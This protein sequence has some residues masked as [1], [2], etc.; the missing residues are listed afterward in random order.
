M[1]HLLPAIASA[2]LTGIGLASFVAEGSIGLFGAT[3]GWVAAIGLSMGVSLIVQRQVVLRWIRFGERPALFTLLPAIVATGLSIVG[4]APGAILIVQLSAM[5][6]GKLESQ[7][8]ETIVP[9]DDWML[10]FTR[11]QVELSDLEA[12]SIQKEERERTFGD[13]CGVQHKKACNQ[14]CRMRARHAATL[15]KSSAIGDDLLESAFTSR[16]MMSRAATVSEQQAAYDS[17]LRVTMSREIPEIVTSLEQVRSDLV[18]GFQED[19]TGPIIKCSD[20]AMVERINEAIELATAPILIPT[21]APSAKAV[22]VNL[23]D[24]AT[25]FKSVFGAEDGCTTEDPDL[26]VWAVIT[27][28]YG[29]GLLLF[30]HGYRRRKLGL[31]PDHHEEFDDAIEP[32]MSAYKLRTAR[33]IDE[34]AF[35]FLMDAGPN[36]RWVVQPANGDLQA[37]KDYAEFSQ[38]MGLGRPK[39]YDQ[40]LAYWRPQWARAVQNDHGGATLWHLVPW[41]RWADMKVK[42]AR[43]RLKER[44][45]ERTTSEKPDE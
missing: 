28:E 13:S 25:C 29:I 8:I 11:L 40:D 27:I 44:N 37:M 23:A 17:A 20:P 14:R 41:P 16:T 15:S 26:I 6:M 33:I 5:E 43:R 10:N 4:S 30:G 45:E 31:V 7:A 36:N 38:V 21:S 19:G 12:L 9:L 18:D 35:R 3:A 2:I 32:R 22:N 1:I 24:A 34:G 39:H 42:I